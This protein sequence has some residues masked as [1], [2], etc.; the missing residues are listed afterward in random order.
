MILLSVSDFIWIERELDLFLDVGLGA[1]DRVEHFVQLAAP[2]ALF[3][4]VAHLALDLG[5]D[6]APTLSSI[7]FSSA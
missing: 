3:T 6:F 7:C 2:G 4:D 5:L 1:L